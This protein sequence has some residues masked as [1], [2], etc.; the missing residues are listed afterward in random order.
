[1]LGQPVAFQEVSLDT[2]RGGVPEDEHLFVD[3]LVGRT[4]VAPP[5]LVIAIANP[6][7][8]FCLR[9]RD[10]IFPDTSAPGHRPR[11]PPGW[12]R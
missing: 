2:E 10:D 4:R 11:P 8:L 6:A 9:H 5:D 12:T 3:Y 7:M 1:M